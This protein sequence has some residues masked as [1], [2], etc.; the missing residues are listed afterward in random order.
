MK[1]IM[2]KPG[3]FER[4]IGNVKDLML[5]YSSMTIAAAESGRS[6]DRVRIYDRQKDNVVIDTVV[7]GKSENRQQKDP[8][9]VFTISCEQIAGIRE[10][11]TESSLCGIQWLLLP[12][13]K[14]AHKTTEHV[15]LSCGTESFEAF[16]DDLFAYAGNEDPING[17]QLLLKKTE[18]ILK[19]NGIDFLISRYE[20]NGEAF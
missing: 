15:F 8:S 4:R 13:K 19:D 14:A 2:K 17:L 12:V 11:I 1:H 16:I 9:Y 18:E 3:V 20:D 10:L 5:S 6:A 7:N